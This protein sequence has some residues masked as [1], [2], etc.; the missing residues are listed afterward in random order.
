MTSEN[1][2]ATEEWNRLCRSLCDLASVFKEERDELR[3]NNAD[4]ESDLDTA[5]AEAAA[6]REEVEAMR[7]CLADVCHVVLTD[8]AVTDT[9]WIDDTTTVADRIA[10]VLKIDTVAP[11]GGPSD[12]LDA[13]RARKVGG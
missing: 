11:F 10:Q 4:M 5:R 8:D 2:R 12:A 13:L 1:D 6:L 3:R 9:L 7:R